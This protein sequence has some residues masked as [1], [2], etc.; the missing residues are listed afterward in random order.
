MRINKDSVELDLRPRFPLFGGWKTQYTLGYNV[1]SYEYLYSSGDQYLLKMRVI[2]HI[3]DDQVIEKATIKII[4]PEGVSNVKLIPPYSVQRLPDQTHYTYLDTVGR[5]V[6]VFTKSN[7]IENHISDFNLRY[8]FTKAL[9]IQEPLLIV[10]FLY[11]LFLIVIVW[12]RLDF[13][14]S[15]P[16]T[17][18]PHPHKD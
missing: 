1:P 16:S 17:Q 14:I 12:T 8:K 13:S 3:F 18:V 9:M 4:L 7:L 11:V 10:G 5:T 2:D 15:K 6:I